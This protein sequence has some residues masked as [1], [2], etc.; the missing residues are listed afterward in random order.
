MATGL[1]NANDPRVRRTRRLLQQTLQE[2]M[3]EKN[4]G[5]ITVQDIAERS[6]LHRTTFYAHF[7]DKYDLLDSVAREGIQRALAESISDDAQLT[8]DTLHICCRTV[9]TYLAGLQ[10][11]CP[12]RDRSLDPMFQT[13]VQEVLRGFLVG[14]LAV[15]SAAGTAGVGTLAT[16]ISWAIFGAASQWSRGARAEP[17]DRMAA[18]LVAVLTEGIGGALAI[19]SS[20]D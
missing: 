14:R 19:S 4:Y 7:E 6:T 3:R 1:V 5:A 9:F 15:S 16:A 2:L 18:Q 8:S 17:A 10:D 11:G 12:S 20:F 13:A